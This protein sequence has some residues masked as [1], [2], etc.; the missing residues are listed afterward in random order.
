MQGFDY[1]HVARHFFTNGGKS[2]N[3][4]YAMPLGERTE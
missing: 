1:R 4:I 3:E 2:K